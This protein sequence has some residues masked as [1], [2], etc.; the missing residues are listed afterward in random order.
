MLGIT[1]ICVNFQYEVHTKSKS[2][3]QIPG[4][5]IGFYL[6]T[7]FGLSS[8][9]LSI[10][11]GFMKPDGIAMEISSSSYALLVMVVKGIAIAP[12]LFLKKQY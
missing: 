2:T 7:L 8:C 4:G 1:V 10:F 6:V 11:L 9:L 12:T 5:K 3:Y